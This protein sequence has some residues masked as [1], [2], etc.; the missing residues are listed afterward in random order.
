MGPRYQAFGKLECMTGSPSET[1]AWVIFLICSVSVS[2]DLA[3]TWAPRRRTR[4][5]VQ[6]EVVALASFFFTRSMSASR[7]VFG[8][9]HPGIRVF[10]ITQ[11]VVSGVFRRDRANDP[12]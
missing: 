7:G 3:A 4:R 10:W 12:L 8:P 1:D 11:A 2:S 9:S 6:T 5:S